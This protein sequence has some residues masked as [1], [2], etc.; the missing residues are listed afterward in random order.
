MQGL[1]AIVLG[2]VESACL[3]GPGACCPALPHDPG[4]GMCPW[5]SDEGLESSGKGG[6]CSGM[7]I[8]VCRVS[9]PLFAGFLTGAV[10]KQR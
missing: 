1:S 8:F 5:T 6:N 4:S 3:P 10:V 2:W 9:R 7:I